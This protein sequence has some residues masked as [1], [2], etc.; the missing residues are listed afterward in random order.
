MARQCRDGLVLLHQGE[1]SE[2]QEPLQPRSLLRAETAGRAL[3]P[4]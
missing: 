1:L 2:W 3:A 4:N